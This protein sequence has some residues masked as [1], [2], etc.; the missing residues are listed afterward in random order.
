MQTPETANW[1]D[2]LV[3]QVSDSFNAARIFSVDCPGAPLGASHPGVVE[4]VLEVI[5][6]PKFEEQARR[7]SIRFTDYNTGNH[8][9]SAV[10]PDRAVAFAAGK[11][12]CTADGAS[13]LFKAI[14]SLRNVACS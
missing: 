5:Y 10:L 1:V 2:V 12:S 14:Q 13:I 11:L 8:A 4:Y 6:P 3:Q 7:A 9:G